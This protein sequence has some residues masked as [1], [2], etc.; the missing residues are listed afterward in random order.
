MIL[1]PSLIA[2]NLNLD[3]IMYPKSDTT[4]I[5]FKRINEM[6]K[7]YNKMSGSFVRINVLLFC[8][9]IAG[10]LLQ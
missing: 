5:K 3:F 10:Q 7:I 9:M 4:K 2:L 1:K 6:G 8:F